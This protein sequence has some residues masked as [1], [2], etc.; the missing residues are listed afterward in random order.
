[1]STPISTPLSLTAE[2]VKILHELI[3]AIDGYNG[4]EERL[5]HD[6]LE[7][8]DPAYQDGSALIGR[9]LDRRGLKTRRLKRSKIQQLFGF[10]HAVSVPETETNT[11]L[12]L[13]RGFVTLFA[14][15]MLWQLTPK[16]EALLER[17]RLR[18]IRG[19]SDTQIEQRRGLFVI[20][21]YPLPTRRSMNGY[22]G[23]DFQVALRDFAATLSQLGIGEPSLFNIGTRTHIGVIAHISHREQLEMNPE[24]E[25]A[26]TLERFE[27]LCRL[28]SGERIR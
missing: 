17:L 14:A 9:L 6:F 10:K 2:D 23:A 13:K 11:T 28:M 8:R 27:S 16:G 12:K 25:L 7:K 19:D 1:M 21:G 18:E 15:P 4:H 3:D 24:L 20:L 5:P 22:R 26:K